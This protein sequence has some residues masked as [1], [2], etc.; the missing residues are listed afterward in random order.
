[1]KVVKSISLNEQTA[2]L[3]AGKINFSAWVRQAL[4]DE[5]NLARRKSTVPVTSHVQPTRAEGGQLCWPFH[6]DGC[7]HLCWPDGPPTEKEYS[8][9]IASGTEILSPDMAERFPQARARDEPPKGQGW[10]SDEEAAL[11]LAPEGENDPQTPPL[12]RRYVRRFLAWA[13]EWI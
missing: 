8:D 3:A 5:A 6:G 10:L 4:L 7:C 2:P 9:W 13:W 12:R 1:M 11:L